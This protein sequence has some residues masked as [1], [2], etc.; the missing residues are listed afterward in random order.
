MSITC[1]WT[2]SCRECQLMNCPTTR[3]KSPA[4]SGLCPVRR[5]ARCHAGGV[6]TLQGRGAVWAPVPWLV[7]PAAGTWER[8]P[9][10]VSSS[11]VWTSSEENANRIAQQGDSSLQRRKCHLERRMCPSLPLHAN[12]NLSS[13][14][15]NRSKASEDYFS[16]LENKSPLLSHCL[17]DDI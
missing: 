14:R 11:L 5:F 1:S 13:Q 10:G 12:G 17:E 16:P 8:A 15:K 7:S 3:T 2:G 9:W 6:A 4:S